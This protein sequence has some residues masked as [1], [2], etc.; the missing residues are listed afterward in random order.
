MYTPT[1]FVPINGLGDGDASGAADG[2]AFGSGDTSAAG[3]A[4]GFFLTH[5]S[6]FLF[7]ISQSAVVHFLQG[8]TCFSAAR[9]DR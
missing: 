9:V 5:K 8:I 2:V 4:A 7:T 1:F 3:D 6:F